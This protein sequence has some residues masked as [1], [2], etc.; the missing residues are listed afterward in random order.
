MKQI[1]FYK[2]TP[3]LTEIHLFSSR[4]GVFLFAF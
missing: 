3:Y 4:L 1:W 2:K